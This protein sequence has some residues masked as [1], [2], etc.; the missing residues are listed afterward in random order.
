MRADAPQSLCQSRCQLI[1]LPRM[2][3]C[4]PAQN[5]LALGRHAQNSPPPIDRISGSNQQL[6]ANSTTL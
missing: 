5:P 6:F 1:Q 3:V 4:K 2:I